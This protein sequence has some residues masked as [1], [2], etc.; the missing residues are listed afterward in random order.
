MSSA[1][2]PAWRALLI[3]DG[4]APGANSLLFCIN[5]AFLVG[6]DVDLVSPRGKMRTRVKA[7]TAIIGPLGL[8]GVSED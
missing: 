4:A 6:V 2:S 8:F 3:L 5:K 1:I 7:R